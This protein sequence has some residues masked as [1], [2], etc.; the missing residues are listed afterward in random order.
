[1]YK[2]K[3]LW[4]CIV[5][6]LMLTTVGIAQDKDRNP[7]EKQLDRDPIPRAVQDRMEMLVRRTVA[8][9]VQ[10]VSKSVVQRYNLDQTVVSEFHQSIQESA[11]AL[12]KQPGGL[13]ALT[14]AARSSN[15]DKMLE[16]LL[17]QPDCKAAFVKYLNEEQLQDY[18]EF[19][20]ARRQRDWGAVARHLAA[21]L[22]QQLSLTV[23]QREKIEQRLIVNADKAGLVNTG[24][25]LWN[26]RH[27]EAVIRRRFKHP[28]DDVLS[29]TQLVIWKQLVVSPKFNIRG[30]IPEHAKAI[31]AKVKA[32]VMEDLKAGNIDHD[33]FELRLVFRDDRR[34]EVIEIEL[35]DEGKA[36]PSESQEEMRRIAEAKLAA[37]TQQ[38]GPLDDSASQRLTLATKGVVEEYLETQGKDWD[39]KYEEVEK[40]IREGV[41]VGKLTHEQAAQ[42]LEGLKKRPHAEERATNSDTHITHHPLYQQTI[43][44]V[45]SEEGFA[46]YKARQAERQ[47]FRQQA[48]RDVLVASID[49]QLFLSDEQ[50]KHFERAAEELFALFAPDEVPALVYIAYQLCQRTDHELLSPWQREEFEK[51]HRELERKVKFS[52]KR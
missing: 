14:A 51:I 23:D 16:T 36:D 26:R 49:A 6:T 1:M 20:L 34:G 21:W 39:S 43:K 2:G 31:V 47:D 10:R 37:Y 19:T 45:L 11:E 13:L 40:E 42:K 52:E 25:I 46:Q 8:P 15:N 18:T 5:A 9:L 41:A 32:D 12:L 38:L 22:D 27:P 48:L 17:S 33:A 3:G 50:R 30:Q 35:W 28:P 7:D 44:D 29:Q 24:D 4:L